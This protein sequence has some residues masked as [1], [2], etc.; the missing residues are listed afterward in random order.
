M[1]K[2]IHVAVA[3]IVNSQQQVLL[4]LR[5]AHQHQ[6]NLW[7]FPGGKVEANEHVFDALRREIKEE[8]DLD[9]TAAAPLLEVSHDY[10]DR[11]VMLDVWHVH[12]F[13]GEPKGQEGQ[14]IRWCAI[15][16][17]DVNEFPS[18]NAAI[19]S[20]LQALSELP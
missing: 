20:A 16:Q 9:I 17:L 18:A 14:Q 8:V 19:V 2:T 5:Q 12:D 11:V 1:N 6:A 7:E 3:A 15:S 13:A 10:G 4:A